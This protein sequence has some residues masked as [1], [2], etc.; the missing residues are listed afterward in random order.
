MGLRHCGGANVY[1]AEAP[2]DGLETLGNRPSGT[3]QTAVAATADGSG[4]GLGPEAV[5]PT[6]RPTDRP[7]DRPSN[8]PSD[9]LPAHGVAA[10]GAGFDPRPSALGCE[11]R[12]DRTSPSAEILPPHRTKTIIALA[13]QRAQTVRVPRPIDRQNT[14]L[15]PVTRSPSAAPPPPCPAPPPSRRR[16]GG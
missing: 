6:D 5:R 7:S 16:A 3:G 15:G 9:H 2:A 1:R 8:R 14:R 10:H 13:A 11:M 12:P 4:G